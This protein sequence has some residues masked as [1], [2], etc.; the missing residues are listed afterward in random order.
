MAHKEFL[1]ELKKDHKEIKGLL[2]EL[3]SMSPQK[4]QLLQQLRREMIP[5]MQAEEDTLYNVLMQ[6]EDSRQLAFKG[7]EE[8]RLGK[9]VMQDLDQATFDERWNARVS[10]LRT[11]VFQHIKEEESDIFDAAKNLGEEQ[12]KEIS[13]SFNRIKQQVKTMVM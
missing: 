5:H 9:M 12:M 3:A 10:L 11:L 8:H 1:D 6:N 7:I 4:A 2:D 13:T